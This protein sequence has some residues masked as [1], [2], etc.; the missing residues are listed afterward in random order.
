MQF[1]GAVLQRPHL[2]PTKESTVRR[3]FSEY[4]RPSD[5]EFQSLWE[6]AEIAFDTSTLLN[7]YRF[8]F[9]LRTDLLEVM[10]KVG[11]QLW[12]PH[13]VAFEYQSNRL[14][15]MANERKV[16][17]QVVQVLDE[18]KKSVLE[19]FN[20]QSNH[21]MLDPEAATGVVDRSYEGIYKYVR[22]LERAHPDFKEDAAPGEQ[23]EVRDSLDRL[24]ADRVGKPFSAERQEEIQVLGLKRYQESVPPGFKDDSKDGT[25]KFG[26]LFVWMQL[27]DRAR[28]TKKPILFVIDDKKEDWWLRQN[29]K[30]V[31]PLPS[32]VREFEEETQQRFYM[33]RSTTFLLRAKDRL[34]ATISPQSMIEIE[35]YEQ[36]QTLPNDYRDAH[37][38]LRQRLADIED[39]AAELTR[40]KRELESVASASAS[41]ASVNEFLALETRRS[42]LTDKLF[43]VM[44]RD[45]AASSEQERRE[46]KRLNEN[47]VAELSE[48]DSRT[49]AFER[50]ERPLEGPYG[51]SNH[52]ESKRVADDLERVKQKAN[53]LRQRIG[54]LGAVADE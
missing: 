37:I 52:E 21:L 41:L 36:N 28:E 31:L 47:L 2:P 23:D 13:Q 35:A 33:Y 49:R 53:M 26:D 10:S 44:G 8:S 38:K 27:I 25:R 24:F 39:R 46:L 17:S 9:Q 7:L 42:M 20:K 22:E 43:E 40:R 12:L 3:E 50:G 51:G 19:S 5:D 18:S 14:K 48:I 1:A 6:S 45:M 34:A 32:L 16:Y 11:D 4:Y 15:V 54:D 29:G 30:V